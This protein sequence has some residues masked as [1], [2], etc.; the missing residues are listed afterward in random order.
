[1]ARDDEVLVFLGR[2]ADSF[3]TT[4]DDRR[5]ASLLRVASTDDGLEVGILDLDGPPAEALLG[6]EVP[7]EWVALGV[8][9]GGW[10]HPLDDGQVGRGCRRRVTSVVIVHRS[11]E[12]V[13][14][15]RVGN[16]EVLRE[17]PAY[18]LILD[19]LQRAF[20]LPTAPPLCSTGVP[21]AIL[22][23]EDIVVAASAG[24]GPFTWADA[25]ALHPAWK[26]FGADEAGP[27]TADLLVAA[28]ALQETMNWECLRRLAIARPRPTPWLTPEE[29]AWCDAGAYS[30]WW[31]DR[32]PSLDFFLAEVRRSAGS[33]VARRCAN[34]LHRL[35]VLSR[36]AA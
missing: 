19:G 11:G 1:M 28:T 8:V 15:L 27:P 6:A 31:M 21:F 4:V 10:A 13:A 17:P 29:A 7:D 32:L 25:R 34:V 36:T 24:S 5:G 2:L 18:G 23:L 16:D 26:V 22:W 9:A 20:G 14:R 30:R 12:I 33:G 35:G 3:C